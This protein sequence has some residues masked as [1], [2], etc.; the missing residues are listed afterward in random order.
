MSNRNVTGKAAIVEANHPKGMIEMIRGDA[1]CNLNDI[2]KLYGKRIDNWTRLQ[3]T[4]ELFEAFAED[5]AYRGL[6]PTVD[7]ALQNEG[8]GRFVAGGGLYAH[9][10]IAIV[11]AQWCSPALALWVSRQIRHLLTYGEVNLHHE[12]WTIEQYENGMQL[13]R[14]D[15]KSMYG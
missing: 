7:R 1:Y 11:F 14:D 8:T 2:A 6:K 4:K 12:E 9:P 13:N 15:I 5:P 10:D 3:G